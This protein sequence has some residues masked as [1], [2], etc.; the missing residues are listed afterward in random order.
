MLALAAAT[1]VWVGCAGHGAVQPRSITIAC[2][3]ANFY[4][5]GLH[6]SRWGAT[7]AA[8]TGTAHQ[9]DCN[10]Y[11]AAGHFHTS[12]IAVRLSKVIVCKGKR[13]F[14]RIEW[15]GRHP[16]GYALGCSR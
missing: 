14:A 6:W 1:I 9:N 4:V 2:A 8:A 7:G 13:E 3:D 11:C 16:G 12:P 10:P 5:T 15:T